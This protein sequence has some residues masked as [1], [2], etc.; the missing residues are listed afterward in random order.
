MTSNHCELC[1]EM[2]NLMLCSRCRDTWYCCREHQKF[3]WKTHKRECGPRGAVVLEQSPINVNS[4]PPVTTT[5]QHYNNR[6]AVDHPIINDRLPQ[7]TSSSNLAQHLQYVPQAPAEFIAAG[8]NEIGFHRSPS[9]PLTPIVDS[10]TFCRGDSS[11]SGGLSMGHSRTPPSG[12]GAYMDQHVRM[13]QLQDLSDYV[14]KCMSQ[15]GICVVDNFL[16]DVVGDK[17][18]EEVL[19]L[20]SRGCFQD[21][22]LV[23][24]RVGGES[25]Q[26]IR[27][28]KITWVE[29]TEKQ[30]KMISHL[31]SSLDTLLMYCGNRLTFSIRGRTKVRETNGG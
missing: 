7:T 24:S 12:G 26:S 21:G 9:Y 5:L 22:Q 27:G 31:I 29:G 3:H 6:P 25:P 11:D 2:D 13:K 30:H 17:I 20:H 19:D 15:H 16:G 28:D 10:P 1:G 4:Y 8:S 14:A 23:N 18:L